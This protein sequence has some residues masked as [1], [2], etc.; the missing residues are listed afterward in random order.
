MVGGAGSVAGQQQ[1]SNTYTELRDKDVSKA[2]IVTI[3]LLSGRAGS[4]AGQQQISNTYTELRDNKL[5]ITK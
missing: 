4:V 3:L 1:I 5:A 2:D